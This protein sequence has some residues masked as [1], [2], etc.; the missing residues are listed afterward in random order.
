MSRIVVIGFDS[1]TDARAALHTLR[2]VEKQ[3]TTSR[4]RP[5]ASTTGA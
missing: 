4:S 5:S 1:E 3:G 2:G